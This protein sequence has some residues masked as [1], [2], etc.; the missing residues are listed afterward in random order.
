MRKRNGHWS[1]GNTTDHSFT[2]VTILATPAGEI[3]P[4]TPILQCQRERSII[5]CFIFSMRRRRSFQYIVLVAWVLLHNVLFHN[6]LRTPDHVRRLDAIVTQDVVGG[7]LAPTYPYFA[8]SAKDTL[9][10][11]TLFHAD[12]LVTAAHCGNV[13]VRTGLYL[14]ATRVNGDDGTFYKVRRSWTHP[15]FNPKTLEHDIMVIQ[16][17]RPVTNVVVPVVDFSTLPDHASVWTLGFGQTDEQSSISEVLRHVEL[18]S[19]P[20]ALCE[21]MYLRLAEYYKISSLRLDTRI[22]VCAAAPGRDA[23]SGDSGGPL[24]YDNRLVGL[25]SWGIGCARPDAPGVFTRLSS[26]QEFLFHLQCTESAVPQCEDPTES[27]TT[28]P[29]RLPTISPTTAP[30]GSPTTSPTTTP[31][32]SPTAVPTA[33]RPPTPVPSPLPSAAQTRSAPPTPTL[34]MLSAGY[35]SLCGPEHQC[36]VSGVAMHFKVLTACINMCVERW[37]ESWDNLQFACGPCPN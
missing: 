34:P 20:N 21:T 26:Y 7:S 4:T 15:S 22:S 14:G 18:Y 28:S 16:L 24:L 25:V 6:V 17:E 9:C 8:V 30:T 33:S 2:S 1:N 12:L 27:P 3:Y 37:H 32:T 11:A 5:Q 10:G 13:F 19:M 29:T 23:C 31:T 36:R 35:A